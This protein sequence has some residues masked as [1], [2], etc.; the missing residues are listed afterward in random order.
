M[1]AIRDVTDEPVPHFIYSHWH[2]D[3][4]GAAHFF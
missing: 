4:V 3:H 2:T 1:S